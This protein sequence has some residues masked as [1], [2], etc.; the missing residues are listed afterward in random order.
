LIEC[1]L[2]DSVSSEPA[3]NTVIEGLFRE[4]QRMLW[5]LS[6]RLTGCAADADDIVQ[7]TFVRAVERE[8]PLEDP[9]WR[10]WLMRVA[11]N[12]GLDG[13]RRRKRRAYP[14][15]WLPSPI[16]TGEQEA[17]VYTALRTPE[18]HYE[19]L[20]SV[21]F[22]FLLALEALTPKQRAVLLLRDVLDYSAAETGAVLAMSAENVR[23]IHHRARAAMR[24]YDTERRPPT[25]ALQ[26]QTRRTLES[27]LRCL[28]TQDAVGLE[29]LLVASVRTVA[30][31][32][33]QYTAL[34]EPL[35]GRVKV[36]LLHLR[37]AKRRS[38]G[39][40]IELRLLNGLPAAVITYASAVRRQA[41]RAVLR[42]DVDVDGRIVALHS[43]LAERKLSAVR[44]RHA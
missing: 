4:H 6:Y 33:G 29:A 8:V 11:V 14:G 36:A 34:R 15:E 24:A 7:E 40:R 39:A 13:L 38:A 27:L 28:V 17:S 19:R 44:F 9:S 41:P 18:G 23:I 5:G 3:P 20:E 12:L 31:G 22:A 26:E 30:D 43:I 42:C 35:I 1:D 2:D 10:P 16:E 37:V 21:S 32:G 25:K